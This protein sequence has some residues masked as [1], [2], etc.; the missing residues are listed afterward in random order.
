M[1]LGYKGGLNCVVL[2]I[3]LLLLWYGVGVWE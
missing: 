2:N 1:K 3:I